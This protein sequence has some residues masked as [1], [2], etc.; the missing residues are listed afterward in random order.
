MTSRWRLARCGMGF[1]VVSSLATVEASAQTVASVHA[2]SVRITGP[3]RV[4]ARW[5]VRR[6]QPHDASVAFSLSRPLRREDGRLAVIVRRSDLSVLLETHDDHVVLPLRNERMPAG[7]LEVE[8][9]LVSAEGSWTELGRFPLRRLTRAGLESLTVRPRVDLQSNGQ[10]DAGPLERTPAP[11][12]GDAFQ[13]V[14]INAGLEGA[15]ARAGVQL[16]WQGV[17]AGAWHESA[18]LRA[19]QLG[20]RAPVMDLASYNLRAVRGPIAVSAGHISLGNHRL[21][22]SQFRS[23]GVGADLALGRRLT[24]AVGSTAGS[25]L[26][27]WGDPFGLARPS[28]RVIAGTVA[29]EALP[30]H[31]GTL[32]L[33]LATLDGSL[34]PL[35]AFSQQAVTDRELSRG[36]GAQF[37]ASIPSQRVR[38]TMGIARSRFDNPADAALARDSS[39]VPVTVETRAAH[40]GE[41]ALDVLRTHMLGPIR[42]SLA[43]SL[44]HERAD[45]LY[46]SVAAFVQADRAQDG[47]DASG[48]LGALQWQASA[49]R[50]RD[51]LANVPSLLVTRTESYAAAATVPFASLVRAKPDAWWAPSLNVTWQATTQRGDTTPPPNSGFRAPFQIPDQSSGN[52]AANAS[53]QRP[54]WSLTYRFNRSLVDNRQA[55]RERADFA[56]AVHGFTLGIN[57]AASLSFGIDLS[58]EAQRSRET[59]TLATNVREGLQADW[60]PTVHT[61]ISAAASLVT[62]H[63]PAATQRAQNVE[64]RLELSQGFN[65]WVRPADGS[66][67]RVFLRWSRTT[68]SLR[69]LEPI[70]MVQQWALSGGMSVRLF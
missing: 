70:P 47:L 53:W 57:A 14:S 2:D 1:I 4:E 31:P 28:H 43:L 64:T 37:V 29:L 6:H 59:G 17:M 18:R 13:D 60:R 44:K 27:G 61:S 11:A 9:F 21:L 38:L 22:A 3:L 56:G 50:A 23:R 26:V 33:E 41:L 68:A 46:R 32:R 8:M 42:T 25:E 52:L 39:L 36:L 34:Q 5:D 54:R 40:F 63:D 19:S 24:I 16:T 62:T 30:S 12:R 48:A 10:L 67:A 49:S 55:E 7:D 20:A 51:N 65:A 69:G 58:H 15:L 35:P 66:Q 45:P